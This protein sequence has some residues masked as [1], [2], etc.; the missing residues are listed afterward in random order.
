MWLSANVNGYRIVIG[1][2]Y[3]PPWMNVN[4]FFGALSESLT[5][6]AYCDKIVLLGDFNI[7][8]LNQNHS[9]YR[10]LA[11]FLQCYDLQ[12]LIDTP[13]H[14]TDTSASLIDVV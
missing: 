11:N 3:R 1:T 14:F 4:I 10:E 7:N 6:Y 12:Q 5:A 9:Y 13:T 2:A 8:C